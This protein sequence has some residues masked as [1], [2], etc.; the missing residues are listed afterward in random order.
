MYD[1]VEN[2]NKNIGLVGSILK[3]AATD[4]L[5]HVDRGRRRQ[6]HDRQCNLTV[7]SKDGWWRWCEVGISMR[8]RID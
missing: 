3:G 1:G 6:F 4:T 8:R 7:R 2:I 5:Q